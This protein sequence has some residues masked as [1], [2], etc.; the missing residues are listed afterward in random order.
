MQFQEHAAHF[1]VN[2]YRS[3]SNSVA[4]RLVALEL[5]FALAKVAPEAVGNAWAAAAD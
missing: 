3:M 2:I 4:D 1:L 5:L